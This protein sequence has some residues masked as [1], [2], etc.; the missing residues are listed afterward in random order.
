MGCCCSC[1][2]SGC[3]N[4]A[5]T[6][7][8]VASSELLLLPL[9]WESSKL[10][11]SLAEP[12]RVWGLRWWCRWWWCRWCWLLWLSWNTSRRLAGLCLLVCS[13]PAPAGLS[14]VRLSSCHCMCSSSSSCSSSN[15]SNVEVRYR[16][17][18]YAHT[19]P[20]PSAHFP[21]STAPPYFM[22]VMTDQYHAWKVSAL[23]WVML[24]TS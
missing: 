3:D 21:C 17:M 16:R 19:H 22:S 9:D 2:D 11:L 20:N 15:R 1:P 6:A 5:P 13:W 24:C 12:G 10:L 18:L 23:S 4:A 14:C 8:A 7:A